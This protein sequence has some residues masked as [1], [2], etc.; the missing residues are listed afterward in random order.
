MEAITQW[1]IFLILN[2]TELVPHASKFGKVQKK[3]K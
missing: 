1:N 2:P 3:K